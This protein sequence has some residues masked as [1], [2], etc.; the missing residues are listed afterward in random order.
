[1]HR[2][3]F[4]TSFQTHRFRYVRHRTILSSCYTS[5]LHRTVQLKLLTSD[6]VI[7]RLNRRQQMP[8]EVRTFEAKVQIIYTVRRPQT[9]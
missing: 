4:P 2:K 7:L 3:P 9:G 5:G 8:P 1:M 6:P